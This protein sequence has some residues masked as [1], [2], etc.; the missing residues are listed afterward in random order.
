MLD[1]VIISDLHLGS[2]NC[3]AKQLCSFLEDIAEGRVATEKLILNGDVF[4]S[5]D[6]RRLGKNHWKVLSLLRKLS[7][8]LEIIWICGNHD[9]S[10]EVVSHLLGVT[11]MEEYLLHRDGRGILILHGHTFDAFIDDHPWL[12]WVGDCIYGLL[13]WLDRS[14]TIARLAKKGSKTFLRCVQK[15]E[16]GAR[17][18]ARKKHLSVVCCGHTHFAVAHDEPSVAYYNSGCWTEAP[19]TYLTVEAGNIQ[20]HTYNRTAVESASEVEKNTEPVLAS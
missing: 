4:D 15:V 5:F 10:A 8:H 17:E 1:A 13:Q 2:S 12:T 7:D 14:H 20:L 6:F 18:H 19:C 3:Q 11:V 16:D 9:G